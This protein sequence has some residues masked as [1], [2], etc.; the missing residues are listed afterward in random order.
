[1]TDKDEIHKIR[2]F[3]SEN[4]VQIIKFNNSLDS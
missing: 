1:M 3:F 2:E 4:K